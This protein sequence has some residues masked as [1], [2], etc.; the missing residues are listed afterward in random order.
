MLVLIDGELEIIT[1][2]KHQDLYVTSAIPLLVCDVWEHA[3]YL[4]YQ[5]KRGDY[6]DNFLKIID[7]KIV[8]KRFEKGLK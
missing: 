8:E 1:I 2:E 4:N 7:W 6:I 3:Y 5:N